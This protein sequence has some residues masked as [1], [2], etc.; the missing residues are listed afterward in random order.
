MA[1]LYRCAKCGNVPSDTLG[2]HCPGCLLKEGLAES[3]A[4][5]P[6]LETA[7]YQSRPAETA[8][9]RTDALPSPGQ[10]FGAYHIVRA[11][12]RGGMGSVFEAEELDSGR[13]LALKVLN[14]SL[15]SP[16]ARQRFLREG[17]LA[18]SVN[19]PQSVF[20]FGTEEIQGAPVITME[21]V[22]GGTLQDRV[23]AHGPL[24][25]QEAVD[26]ILQIVDGLEAAQ[27][28]GVLHRDIKPANCSV[29]WS[30]GRRFGDVWLARWLWHRLHL[31][32]IVARHLPQGRHTVAPADIVAIE[33]SN[34]LCA[35]CSEFA[36]AEHWYA[37]TALPDLLGVP[38]DAVTKDRLY[39]T[40]DA[41]LQVKEPIENDLKEQLGTLFRLDYD[42]LLY[43]LTSTYF[44]GLA[45][46]NDLARRGYSRDHRSDCK[47]V[48]LA[49][50]VTRDGFPLAH[51][52]LAGN[53]QD[54]EV[55]A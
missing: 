32:A 55:H 51:V 1:E 8:A 47:Q 46:E 7:A 11:L 37:A 33:V 20:V 14:H 25:I 26:A 35:P 6:G 13:R 16:G 2:G 48:V 38:D 18:A 49:L 21:L 5:P 27:A 34:R 44:E 4:E 30:N 12:G 24:P 31:D 43:D 45:E 36:L 9:P 53:T 3:S 40:L 10:D 17:R 23:R 22:Q 41:L 42:L 15:D 19:H 54:V 52:T 28:V 29:G 39:R 50:V